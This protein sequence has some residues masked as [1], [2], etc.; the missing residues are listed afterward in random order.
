MS[1]LHSDKAVTGFEIS[2]GHILQCKVVKVWQPTHPIAFS[3]YWI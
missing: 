3:K 1:G 2:L